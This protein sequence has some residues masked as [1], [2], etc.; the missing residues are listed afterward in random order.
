VSAASALESAARF[1][2][3]LLAAYH[4][5]VGAIA[6][7]A[8][9]RAA[10]V[11]RALYGAALPSGDA[12]RYAT[13]M[14]GA[15]ALAIGLVAGVAALAPAQHRAIIVALLVLQLGRI[16]CRLRDR[17]LLASSLGVTARRN[18]AAIIVLGAECAVLGLWLR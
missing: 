13:S 9:A 17:R 11:M 18:G 6:L 2:L 16:F 7:V 10:S 12:F 4:V 15:L 1:V 14:I 3:W 5:V 8:P